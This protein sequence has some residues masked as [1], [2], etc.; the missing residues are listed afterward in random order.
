MATTI[1]TKYGSDAPATT[2]IVRGELAVDTENGRLYTENSSAA[3][4]ELGSNPSGNITFGDN[5]KAIF[6]AGSDL[7]IYH[8][9]SN[10]YIDDAGTGSLVMRGND[11]VYLQ[12]YTGE[13][14]LA[15]RADGAVELYHN[16]ALK[17]ATT[18]TGI[19]VTG[20]ATMDGLTVDKTGGNIAASFISDDSNNSYVQFQNAT[21]GTTTYTDG[22]LVGIDS[23]ESLTIWQL[24]SNHI[25]FGTA[26][27]ER[28]RIDASGNLLVGKTAL[29]TNTTGLQ[30]ESDGYLSA[31]R[32][33]G[34]VVLVN[35]KSS[36]GALVTLQKD[37]TTVGSIGN[38]GTTAMY[39]GSGDT[40][41]LFKADEDQMV[42]FSAGGY[43][44]DAI[45][46][47][48]SNGRFKDLYL[49]GNANLGYFT[50]V[51]SGTSTQTVGLVIDHGSST[52][53]SL[54]QAENDNGTWFSVAGDGVATFG[55][56]ANF[57]SD[58]LVNTTSTVA[59]AH[60]T[61]ACT[62]GSGAKI[63]LTL[64]TGI[65]SDGFTC[66]SLQNQAG[67][68]GAIVVNTSSVSYSTSSDQRLKENIA[69]ADDAGS[70]VDAIQ[71]RKF[72][73]KA[74]GSH[75]D[76]GMIAQELIEVA[77]EAVSAPEDPEEMMGVDYSKLVPMLVKEIQQLRQRVAQLEE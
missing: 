50:K 56:A 7:Q 54:I 71:V 2:D 52:S 43:R 9:G 6:G 53:Y 4:V 32:D 35:R 36:D 22:S 59:A 26:A 64:V 61:I 15:A 20:I 23:D 19:D 68:Q 13:N 60:Q 41:L 29:N 72:D 58:V 73:W 18:A 38:S 46:L 39:V 49:S 16:D 11:A 62:A 77:P 57:N 14:M 44:D 47:G 34:N 33:G 66:V 25:K 10:S 3:V 63:P 17:L 30:L 31:C 24:E 12:K 70:K 76:Y 27:T 5:G 69:D 55:G 45:S 51:G 21:T 42:P 74:D 8:D 65:T 40:Q 28:M 37:G 1:V 75:Q 48:R 67:Q